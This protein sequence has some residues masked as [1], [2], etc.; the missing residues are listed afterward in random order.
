VNGACRVAGMFLIL[1]LPIF[2]WLNEVLSSEA[3]VREGTTKYE[4]NRNLI[5]LL[6]KYSEFP[7]QLN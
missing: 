1:C 4:D 5:A 2:L 7:A 6:P 3:V